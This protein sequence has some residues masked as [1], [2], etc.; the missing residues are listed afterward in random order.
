MQLMKRLSFLLILLALFVGH[1]AAQMVQN[2]DF[3][4]VA[5]ASLPTTLA[6]AQAGASYG[7]GYQIV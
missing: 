4:L 7:Y 5:G 3:F 1:A 6:P 2:Q